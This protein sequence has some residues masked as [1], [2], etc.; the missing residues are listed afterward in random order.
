VGID[1]FEDRDEDGW[2][3]MGGCRWVGDRDE[4]GLYIKEA[5]GKKKK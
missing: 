4:D 5:E 3:K 1:G 2:V